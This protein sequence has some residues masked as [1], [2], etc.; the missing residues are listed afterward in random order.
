MAITPYDVPIP[1]QSLTMTP[2]NAPW[3]RPPEMSD[4]KEVIDSYIEF[5]SSEDVI[6]NIML[7]LKLDAPVES[8]VEALTTLGIYK[9]QHSPDVK[10]LVAPVVHKYIEVMALKAGVPVRNIP[11]EDR[12][13]SKKERNDN[14]VKMLLEKKINEMSDDEMDEG[15]ELMEQTARVLN[16]PMTRKDAPLDVS[17]EEEE[18][19]N[20][21]D[22]P[23][24]EEKPSSLMSRRI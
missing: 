2:K 14:A 23:M 1:G 8:I 7:M 19:E 10:L 24:L 18:V 5:M 9:G 20:I 6:D 22:T 11:E 13:A 3:E 16:E 4:V 12:E 15:V 21:E 17:T